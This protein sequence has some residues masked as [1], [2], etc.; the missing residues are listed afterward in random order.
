M[1]CGEIVRW[2]YNLWLSL[3]KCWATVLCV[4][5]CVCDQLVV[6]GIGEAGVNGCGHSSGLLVPSL[7]SNVVGLSV[8]CV[9]VYM[10]MWLHSC[11]LTR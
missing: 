3:D 1:R 6:V 11:M 10:C 8:V 9:C 2:K 7:A 5:V 4:Y